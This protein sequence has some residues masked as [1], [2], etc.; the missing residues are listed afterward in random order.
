MHVEGVAKHVEDDLVI[1]TALSGRAAFLVTSD[2]PFRGVGEYQGV[3]ILTPREF[4][5]LLER[6]GEE[7]VLRRDE[8]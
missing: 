7:S 8:R 6:P 3:T 5:D 4:L 1:A 2:I